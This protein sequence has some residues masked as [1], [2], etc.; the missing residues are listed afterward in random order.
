MY[1]IAMNI[2][3]LEP[4]VTAYTYSELYNDHVG[5]GDASKESKQDRSTPRAG[6]SVNRIFPNDT[7]SRFE[8]HVVPVGLVYL[9]DFVPT[10]EMI[11]YERELDILYDVIDDQFFNRL[12]DMVSTNIP[13]KFIKTST[14]LKHRESTPRKKRI[15]IR[16]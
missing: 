16:R 2:S 15:T 4:I 1:T 13:R 11:E 5:G 6:L 8:N 10:K 9:K 3:I 12:I 14:S 7:P